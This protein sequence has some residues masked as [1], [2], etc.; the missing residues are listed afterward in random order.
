MSNFLIDQLEKDINQ[1][2]MNSVPDKSWDVAIVGSG[3]A[4]A[5]A[6]VHLTSKGHSVLL[7]DKKQFPREK[8]CGDGLISDSLRCLKRAGIY[9]QVCELG[10]ESSQGVVYSPSRIE[11]NVTGQF[12]TLKR[13][14]L[15]TLIVRKASKCGAVIAHGNVKD[16]SIQSN[17]NV[18]YRVEGLSRPVSAFVGMVATG[19]KVSL[20]KRLNMVSQDNPTAIAMRCYLK[21]SAQLDKLVISYDKSIIPGYAWIFPLGNGEYNM[22]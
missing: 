21:S 9:K 8:V 3:P 15:D 4:G 17:G 16:I 12:V 1:L 13:F 2:P 10:Y 6:A 14:V 5:I 19:A 20:L 7:L 22:G 11:M 18:T